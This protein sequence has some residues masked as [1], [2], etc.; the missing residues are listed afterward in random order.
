MKHI[1]DALESATGPDRALDW[2]IHLRHGIDGAGMYG[3]HPAYTSS[4]DA[5]LT[6]VPRH[7]LWE[8]KQGFQSK[9]TVWM[10][11]VDYDDR[12]PPLG[13]STTFPAIA[14]CIAAMKADLEA[15]SR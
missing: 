7:H 4:L 11:E 9:A 5:A 14:L 3:E 15:R 2:E 8:V 1:I 10:I 12:D 6:V 13:Y